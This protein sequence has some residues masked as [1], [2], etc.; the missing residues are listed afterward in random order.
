MTGKNHVFWKVHLNWCPELRIVV[1]AWASQVENKP[2]K[3]HKVRRL[4]IWRGFWYFEL[5]HVIFGNKKTGGSWKLLLKMYELLRS[6]CIW[7][8]KLLLQFLR[9]TLQTHVKPQQCTITN[10]TKI[11]TFT[12]C[13]HDPQEWTSLLVPDGTITRLV[14]TASSVR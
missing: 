14:N 8:E 11:L 13:S 5:L 4:R 10:E 2:R 9:N 1:T 12:P 6:S 3:S 7:N